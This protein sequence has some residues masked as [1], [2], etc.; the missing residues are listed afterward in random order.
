MLRQRIFGIALGYED[1]NDFDTLRSDP[2][3]KMASERAP[4][5]GADLASQPTLSRLENS[6]EARDLLAMA[7]FLVQLFIDGHRNSKPSQ[8]V[9]DID[10]TDDPTHGQQELEF[11]HGYYRSHCFLPLVVYGSAD[12]GEQEL[13]AAVL[14]PGNKHAGHGSVGV[15]RRIV[16]R[17]REAFPACRFIVRGDAGF[18]LPALYDWC[19]SASVEYVLSLGK[20]SRLLELSSQFEQEAREQ[21]EQAQIKVRHFGEIVYAAQTWPKARRVVVKA[22]MMSKGYNPR[23]VVTNLPGDDTIRDEPESVYGFYTDRGDVENRIKELKGD[24]LSGRTSCH[25]FEANQFRLLLHAFAFAIM[26]ALRRLLK[27]TQ[28]AQWQAG[29][30]CT[31]LLKVATLVTESFRRIVFKLPSSY[32]FQDLWKHLAV[33]LQ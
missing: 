9:L 21:F 22:E 6:V 13:L 10:A 17:L 1:C 2:L 7:D 23:F 5:S 4:I 14:R 28:G 18:A 26:Q 32:P 12:G 31:K 27:G 15:L 24:L 33:Q 19:E 25:R 30:L 16:A 20:N 3:F 29:T 11:Y 8:I